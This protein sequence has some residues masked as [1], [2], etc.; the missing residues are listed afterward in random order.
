MTRRGNI[1]SNKSRH[2]EA[3]LAINDPGAIYQGTGIHTSLLLVT[4]AGLIISL[5]ML[6]SSIFGKITAYVGILANMFGWAISS[7]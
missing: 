2:S 3:L 4:L 7:H 1:E 6:R 5:V